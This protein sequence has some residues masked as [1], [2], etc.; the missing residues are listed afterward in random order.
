MHR[1]LVPDSKFRVAVISPTETLKCWYWLSY[2]RRGEVIRVSLGI[3]LGWMSFRTR[4]PPLHTRLA[5]GLDI[6]SKG[7]KINVYRR[8]LGARPRAFL[9]RRKWCG[10]SH[11][12]MDQ[13]ATEYR[14]PPGGWL[15]FS[16]DG[17]SSILGS[18]SYPV[19]IWMYNLIHLHWGVPPSQPFYRPGKPMEFGSILRRNRA[20][21]LDD[22]AQL[23]KDRVDLDLALLE[24]L[25]F[26]H[27]GPRLWGVREHLLESA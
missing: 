1:G 10:L 6:V 15:S 22:H 17:R 13:G 7:E 8:R 11:L 18:I 12:S 14:Q 25:L 4:K 21:L 19:F 16:T 27:F 3:R 9:V 26:P 5:I 20:L 23:P 2:T 24:D